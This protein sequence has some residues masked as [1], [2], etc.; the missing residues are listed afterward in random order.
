[1][2]FSLRWI[3]YLA[4]KLFCRRIEHIFTFLHTYPV[5]ILKFTEWYLSPIKVFCATG[6]NV[7]KFS[8]IAYHINIYMYKYS[9]YITAVGNTP[10]FLNQLSVD[11]YK[12]VDHRIYTIALRR[13]TLR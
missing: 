7:N 8:K 1:M 6:Y 10:H 13:G 3:L 4:E 12:S 5:I 11:Y 2:K 9:L